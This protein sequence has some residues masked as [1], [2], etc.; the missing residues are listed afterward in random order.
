MAAVDHVGERVRALRLQRGLSQEQLAGPGVSASYVSLIESGR[1]RPSPDALQTLATALGTSAEFLV[2]GESAALRR[3]EELDLRLAEGALR[4]GDPAEAERRFRVLR[5]AEA[6]PAVRDA[7]EQ[8]LAQALEAQ[9]RLEEAIAGY[10][11]IRARANDIADTSWLAASIALVRCYREVGDL[12]RSAD[13]GE[14]AL[15]QLAGLGLPGTDLHAQLGAS[16]AFT[17]YER[18]DLV[19]ARQLID[20]VMA[21]SA[22]SGSPAA[23]GAAFWNAAVIAAERGEIGTAVEL[24]ERALLLFHA[25]GETRNAARLRN[26][27]AA[28]LLLTDPPRPREALTLLESARDSLAEIGSLTDQAYCETEIARA[29]LMLGD[30]GA[31]VRAAREALHH[32]PSADDRLERSRALAV[33]ADAWLASGDPEAAAAAYRE[34]AGSMTAAGAGRQAARIWRQLADHLERA[35]DV[36]GALDAL[37]AATAALG[38]RPEATRVEPVSR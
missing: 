32:L 24:S 1:R 31:A 16:V 4:S 10:E 7:V 13:L 38:V 34:A 6:A 12:G 25:E 35:G 23:Q 17:A 33:L 19:R 18:G 2:H 11:A 3:Q 37:K 9:G 20:R 21:E 14:R 15:E 28:L 5:T 30:A 22:A 8:G 26:S 29:H 36:A 27:Y